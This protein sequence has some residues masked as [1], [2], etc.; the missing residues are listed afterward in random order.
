MVF[1]RIYFVN[2]VIW[3]NPISIPLFLIILKLISLLIIVS[4][5]LVLTSPT[6]NGKR[7]F[8]SVVNDCTRFSWLY[9]LHTKYQTVDAFLDFKQMVEK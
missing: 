5:L 6:S 4:L 7:Y 2:F 8:L 9:V 1:L 3:L